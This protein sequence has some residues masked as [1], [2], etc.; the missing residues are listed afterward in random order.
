MRGMTRRSGGRLMHVCTAVVASLV[1]SLALGIAGSQ[2]AESLPPAP[3]PSVLAPVPVVGS[4]AP[5]PDPAALTRLVR[6]AF[7]KTMARNAG[8]VVVDPATGRLLLDE[9]GDTLR[10]PA[11][12]MKLLTAASALVSLPMDTRLTTRVVVQDAT[13]TLIGGGDVTLGRSRRTMPGGATLRELAMQVAR[14]VGAAPVTLQFDASAFAGPSTAPGWPSGMPR[15][16]ALSL[17]GDGGRNPARRAAAAFAAE[18][19]R[20]G[21]VVSEPRAGGAPADATQIAMVASPPL[22]QLVEHML[23][24]SDNLLAESLAHLA[25]AERFGIADFTSGGRATLAAAKELGI[26]LPPGTRIV[27]GSGLSSDDAVPSTAL[28]R[29]LTLVATGADPRL[30]PIASGLP[31]AG[32]TGTLSDRFS[33]ASQRAAAGFVRAK[34]GTL[35][36]VVALAGT[37]EDVD[38]RVLVFAVLANDV[39]SVAK[40]RGI[41]DGFV[42]QLFECGCR[43]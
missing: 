32:V 41:A 5:V 3:A 4:S 29:L 25:G 6:T 26:A 7:P 18:L 12:T 42:S 19:R 9:Q 2:A 10:T 34:T 27:D 39:R 17:A 24:E 28:T 30:A 23:T 11:S 13:I 1:A 16:S 21:V 40:A 37:V 35:R 33:T 43:S 8:I 31:V 15:L 14:Q 20:A 38:G 22:P 36:T